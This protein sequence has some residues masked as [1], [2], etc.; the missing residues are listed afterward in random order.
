MEVHL[1]AELEDKLTQ[2]AA[3]QGRN[4]ESLVCEAVERLVGQFAGVS[5]GR[6][7]PFRI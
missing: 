7:Q 3:Q 5:G 2:I 1:S 6:N 4:T